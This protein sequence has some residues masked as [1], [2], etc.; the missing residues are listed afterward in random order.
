MAESDTEVGKKKKAR[1]SSNTTG[2]TTTV[3]SGSAPVSSAP[4]KDKL[5]PTPKKS[6]AAREYSDGLSAYMKILAERKGASAQI[7]V[8]DGELVASLS[9][10]GIGGVS[11]ISAHR[12]DVILTFYDTDHLRNAVAKDKIRL[13]NG[14]EATIRLGQVRSNSEAMV[15]AGLCIITRRNT[16]EA[17]H[18]LADSITRTEERIESFFKKLAVFWPIDRVE[19]LR[20][21]VKQPENVPKNLIVLRQQ[22]ER[23]QQ[24][25]TAMTTA[26]TQV[27]L[28]QTLADGSN[29][30]LKSSDA[31]YF[32]PTVTPVLGV[33]PVQALLPMARS[34]N[35]RTYMPLLLASY[36]WLIRIPKPPYET[37]GLGVF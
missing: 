21:F 26:Q 32:D 34:P 18:I 14:G 33:H 27:L 36:I 17:C 29:A 10:A 5:G 25:L 15:M 20:S 4:V 6:Y 2:D 7:Q 24:D 23:S 31:G 22:G 1:A 3:A 28:N 30:Y 8:S 12:D 16:V 19:H 13:T 11:N 35:I 37:S 9:T